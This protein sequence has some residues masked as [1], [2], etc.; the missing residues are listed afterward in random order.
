MCNRT[1]PLAT[2]LALAVVA[3]CSDDPTGPISMDFEW[4]G[5]VLPG[6]QIE[7]KGISGNIQFTGDQGTQV[8]V[9]ATK[10]G[11]Q[12]DVA[13][14]TIEV[15]T[16]AGGVT[17]CAVYPDVAGQPPNVC[18]PDDQGHLSAEDNDVTVDFTVLVPEGVTAVG[19]TVAG[20]V[21]ADQLEGDV[22]AVTVSGNI[23]LTTTTIATGVT[24]SGIV[25]ADIGS[26]DWGRDLEFAAVSGS[27]TVTVPA[28]TNAFVVA[29]VVSGTITSDF[30]LTDAGPGR[31]EGTL[32]SGGPTL[33]L[34]AVSGNVTLRRGP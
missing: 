26:A 22:F 34:A 12:S 31:R 8:V 28:A 2:A 5:T 9:S 25:T 15:V 30:P 21:G 19:K 1:R 24:V 29:T 18:G 20:S 13:S 16:H 32:G 14:V 23:D 10:T 7:I 33:A 3:A 6:D 27:V 17:I 11:G 4:S